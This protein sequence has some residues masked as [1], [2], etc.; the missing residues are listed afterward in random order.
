M[1][2]A[3]DRGKMSKDKDFY[4]LHSEICKSLS[5]P[6]R[7]EILDH[8]RKE[9]L[10]VQE[11]IQRTGI[12]QSNLSQHLAVLRGN[13]VVTTHQEG[14]HVYYSISNSKIIQAFDLMSEVLKE[15]LDQ[16]NSKVKK[17]LG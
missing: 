17:V 3:G 12:S 16:K 1:I 7:Q 11:L 13:G 9:S 4:I 15:T 8:L 2:C 6:K 5:N 14:K 10:T